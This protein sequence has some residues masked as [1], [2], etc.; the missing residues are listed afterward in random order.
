MNILIPQK[1]IEIK[2]YLESEEIK[3]SSNMED[4]R[5]NSAI[6]EDVI[7][8]LIQKKF[9]IGVPPSRSWVDFS[10]EEQ[11]MFI[12]V[13]IKITET[14]KNDNLNCKL[15][16]YYALCGKLPDFQNEISWEKYFKK[17][18]ENIKENHLD[19]YFLVI[20]K[21]NTSEI[22]VNSLKKLS[23]LQPN[24]NNLPFQCKWNFNKIPKN[25]T[26]EEAKNFL[27]KNLGKSV[28][29]RSKIYTSFKTYFKEF[30]K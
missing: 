2:E 22:I 29:L 1:L 20:N 9:E 15:G 21:N 10:F 24:G 3:L 13:N 8:K 30:L 23:Q 18:S 19:Y 17:L 25:K 6:N 4:G 7:M 14:T 5:I 28:V 12:P 16:L 27:L 26:F 11:E